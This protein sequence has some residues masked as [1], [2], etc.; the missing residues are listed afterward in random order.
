MPLSTS[1]S[2]GHP[3]PWQQTCFWLCQDGYYSQSSYEMK[4]GIDAIQYWYII[5]IDCDISRRD[6]GELR[7]MCWPSICSWGA[8]Q[9]MMRLWHGYEYERGTYST[10]SLLHDLVNP[11]QGI[12][13]CQ[14]IQSCN[15]KHQSG[16]K[17][18]HQKTRTLCSIQLGE[19]ILLI[20][21]KLTTPSS[22]LRT[23]S[24]LSKNTKGD[25]DKVIRVDRWG[26]CRPK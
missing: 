25:N 22:T 23:M 13:K 6:G 14:D 3:P 26:F 1:L 5:S 19:G 24:D 9:Q 10:K 7:R 4:T 21:L 11:M 8:G 20:P 18:Y 15:Q 2:A 12:C 16:S 17:D